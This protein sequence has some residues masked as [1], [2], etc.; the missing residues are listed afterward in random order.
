MVGFSHY[1]AAAAGTRHLIEMGYRKIGFI[2]ARMDPRAKRRL[3]GLRNTL[4]Q[5]GILDP[6]RMVTTGVR[7]TVTEGGILLKQLMQQAPDTDAVLCNND[8]LALGV[9]FEAQREGLSIP[10]DFGICGFNDMEVT[11]QTNPPLTS[12]RTPRREVGRRAVEM[13]IARLEGGTARP[14]EDLGFEVIPRE[15][16]NR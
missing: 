1:D 16:T 7:T 8:D 13:L 2:G 5:A 9:L 12:V 3:E 15:S 4:A 10:K 6:G 11:S 14:C